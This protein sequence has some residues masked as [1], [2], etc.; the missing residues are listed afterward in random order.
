MPEKRAKNKLETLN[1][2]MDLFNHKSNPLSE[3]YEAKGKKTKMK[4]E[5]ANDPISKTNVKAPWTKMTVPGDVAIGVNNQGEEYTAHTGPDYE[6]NS[7]YGKQRKV[8]YGS[9]VKNFEEGMSRGEFVVVEKQYTGSL[10]KGTPIAAGTRKI[11]ANKLRSIRKGT[12]KAGSQMAQGPAETYKS[13]TMAAK[14]AARDAGGSQRSAEKKMAQ[15]EDKKKLSENYEKGYADK[16]IKPGTKEAK[17]EEKRRKKLKKEKLS[18]DYQ[19]G[20]ADM[21]IKPGTKKAKAEEKRR[22]KLKKGKLGK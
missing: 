21:G 14:L 6:K 18:E 19:Q 5:K 11:M 16:G 7:D 2:N 12:V 9:E 3:A 1:N 22:K 4:K 15:S 8:S 17:A 20:Y 13:R 10:K